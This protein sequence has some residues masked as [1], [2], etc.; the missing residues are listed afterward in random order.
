M[1]LEFLD[2]MESNTQ[3]FSVTRDELLLIDWHT[4]GDYLSNHGHSIDDS[5][6]RWHEVRSHI[7]QGLHLI[8][9]SREDSAG[10][11]FQIDEGTAKWLFNALPPVFAFGTA[12]ECG[13]TLKMKLYKYLFGISDPIVEEESDNPDPDKTDSDTE[14]ATEPTPGGE[15][16]V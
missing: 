16:S 5:I 7:W 2:E 8:E 12:K 10:F 14:D 11:L 9:L 15:A 4:C 1:V 6:E 13:Y 3:G